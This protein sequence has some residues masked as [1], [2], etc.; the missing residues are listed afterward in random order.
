MPIAAM[1]VAPEVAADEGRLRA[2]KRNML[3]F[4]IHALPEELHRELRRGAETGRSIGQ[5]ARIGLRLGDKFRDAADAGGRPG[6]N[7]IGCATKISDRHKIFKRVVA[8]F[9]QSW[10]DQPAD[11]RRI[12]E[13]Q[14][15]IAVR[16]SRGGG[17]QTVSAGRADGVFNSDTPSKPL[18]KL[19]CQQ[20]AK[21]VSGSAG[22]KRDNNGD[23]TVGPVGASLTAQDDSHYRC[24]SQFRQN[25]PHDMLEPRH[26]R[27]ICS[28]VA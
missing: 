26:R 10:I 15:S 16:R 18:A 20:A 28:C 2:K 12:G 6:N 5:F 8:G 1:S 7:D 14:E 23:G 9:G 27:P 19:R 4:D 17:A 25:Q 3:D 13:Y 22:G 21:Q 11:Q 24:S